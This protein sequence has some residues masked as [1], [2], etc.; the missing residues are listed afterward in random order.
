M[1][2]HRLTQLC[3]ASALTLT[4]SLTHAQVTIDQNKAMAGN[5]TPGD[6]PGFPITI[7]RPGLYKLVSNLSV[8]AGTDGIRIAADDVTLDMNG[9]T[10][11]ST[12]I[13]T[14]NSQ[15]RVVT[16]SQGG[17][18]GTG[19]DTSFNGAYNGSVVRDGTVRGFSKG[20]RGVQGETLLR[21]H[22]TQNESYGVS[23]TTV[24]SGITVID[25]VIDLNG[26][27][28]IAAN[29][30]LMRGSRV[31]HN[32]GNGIQT[33]NMIVE[34]SFVMGNKNVGMQAGAARGS[35]LLG[36]GTN[37]DSVQSLGGNI[38]NSVIF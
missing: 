31:G 4:A 37:R 24:F 15:S 16:C 1:N 2:A 22:I 11:A 8:P 25:S 19:I 28:G 10:L 33:S 3:V 29:N 5:V 34:S 18:A 30:G 23:T 20:L 36:N 13:C 6:T 26:F 9:F 7:T 27:T 35:W 21:M 12:A 32:G 14:R 38:D 17:G